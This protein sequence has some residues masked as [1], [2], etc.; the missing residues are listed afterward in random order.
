M[1]EGM[2]KPTNQGDHE[3]SKEPTNARTNESIR[4]Y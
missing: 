4:F 3:P 2:K 1:N